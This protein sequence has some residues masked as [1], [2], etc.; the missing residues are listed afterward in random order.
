MGGAG[1]GGVGGGGGAGPPKSFLSEVSV[2]FRLQDCPCCNCGAI[3]VGGKGDNEQ[4]LVVITRGS[5][6]GN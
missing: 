1:S 3:G 4:I 6:A 2:Q 5:R